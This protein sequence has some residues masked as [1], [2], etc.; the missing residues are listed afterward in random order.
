V[1][2]YLPDRTP[3][4]VRRI[5][6]D[7]KRFLSAGLANLS[8]TSV[9]RR[10]LAP[11]HRFT[12]SELRYLTEVDGFN[13]VAFVAESPVQPSRHLIGVARFVRDPDDPE[14]AE[15]AIVVADD[16]QG[17]GLGSLLARELASAARQLGVRRFTAT[18]LA[19]N[20]PAHRLMAKLADHLEERPSGF[21]TTE[22]VA[23]LAA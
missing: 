23:D 7:D 9:Q 12:R 8:E 17:H 21:G 1:L 16:W 11:K 20:K 10:F 18:M 15:A 19:E 13:H 2:A 4:V 14:S 22:T 3:V 6:A 5:R